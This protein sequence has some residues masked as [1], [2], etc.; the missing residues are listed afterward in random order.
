MNHRLIGSF[1]VAFAAITS[2]AAENPPSAIRTPQS[3][4]PGRQPDGSV[5]LPNLWSLRPVGTQIDLGDFPVN[6]AVHP[7]SRFAAVL[8]CGFG[9]NEIVVVDIP[10]AKIVSRTRIA[11]AFYGLEFSFGGNRL[12]CSG[13][14]NEVIRVFNFNDGQLE[15]DRVIPLRDVK[16]RGI[17]G[18]MAVSADAQN[19]YVANV[20]GQRVAKVDLL[21]R[22]NVLEIFFGQSETS[23]SSKIQSPGKTVDF[24]TAA[25]T[26]R[27][28][29]QFDPTSPDAPFPYACRLDERRQRLY[30]SLWAQATVAVI[31]LKSNRVVARWPTEE[32]PNEMLLTKSGKYLYV[33]N[34]N[35]NTVTVFDTDKER[36]I[37]TIWAALHPLGL[38]GST[39]NSLALS[40]DEKTLFVANAC[41]NNVAVF[42][43]SFRGKSRSMGFIPV[44]WYPTSVRVTRDGKYLLVANGKGLISK[45]NPNGPRPDKKYAPGTIVEHIGGLMKGTLSVIDL[46]AREKFAAQLKAYTATAYR[47]SPLQR[48]ASVGATRPESNPIPFKVGDASPIK[49]CIYVIKENRTYD[50]VLGD[51]PQGNGDAKLCLFPEKV[52]PNH[53]KIAREFVLLD[54]F[55]VEGEVSADGHEWSMGAYATDFVE[56]FWPLSYGHNGHKKYPYPAEGVFPVAL[57]ASGYLWD[58]A[59]EAGVSYRSYGEFINNARTPAEPG[60]TKVASLR[61]HFD[62]WFF[63]FDMDYSDLKRADRFIAELKRF[64]QEGDMPRLQIVRL[65]NDHTAGTSP[66]KPTP[67]AYVAENDLAFGRFVEAVSRSKF[68]PQTAIF[69]VEDDAQNGPDHVDAHRTIAFVIS[70]YTKRNAVDSTMYS[71]SSMLRTMELILGLKPMT[72]FDAAA[73]PMFNSFQ[74]KPDLRSYAALPAN[75]DLTERNTKLAWGSEKS[76]KMDFTKEDAADDLLLNEVIWRSVKGAESP[77]PA[78]VRAAFVFVHPKDED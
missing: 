4:W 73:T 77:M 15:A 8:H 31:D 29:A 5:L 46:P 43:V 32:H 35:R 70:P 42:D 23:L 72:Q 51:M 1:L 12:Y 9:P 28:E 21:A 10:A 56:K 62:P 53:H 39:P 11:E 27:A 16:E 57:P 6:I 34:A 48:D 20:W 41:N 44:G 40:P 37:E 25:I 24:D 52:T 7:D 78:P 63:S 17:P 71:T 76:R 68:W 58:R 38:S 74:P 50:Q 61:D 66:G 64:E 18:G 14:G 22:T 33:A 13:A 30:V 60:T 55:Y 59:R 67:T 2:A 36:A 65:P 75:V 45:A 47:C 54:N 19:L 69:V 3:I 49:Y 26:K